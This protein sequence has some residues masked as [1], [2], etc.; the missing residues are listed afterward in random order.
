MHM[1]RNNDEIYA[2]NAISFH[3]T[4]GTFATAGS[5]GTATSVCI[6]FAFC[7][8]F[9]GTKKILFSTTTHIYIF[10]YTSSITDVG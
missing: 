6:A 4:Y 7:P 1:H 3:P 2:V 5:D 8:L 10:Y 9:D